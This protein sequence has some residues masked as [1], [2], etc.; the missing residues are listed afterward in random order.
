[1][2]LCECGE[3]GCSNANIPGRVNDEKFS[4]I[5]CI[6]LLVQALMLFMRFQRERARERERERD[7]EIESKREAQKDA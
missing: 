2:M 1:M 4:R 6:Q 3:Y 7:W 5:M